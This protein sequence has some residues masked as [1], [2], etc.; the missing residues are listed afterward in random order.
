MKVILKI[1]IDSDQPEEKRLAARGLA[2]LPFYIVKES[3]PLIDLNLKES[4]ESFTL[5]NFFQS[6]NQILKM[7]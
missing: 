4:S 3:D 5:M 6:V 2:T 1:C 7:N